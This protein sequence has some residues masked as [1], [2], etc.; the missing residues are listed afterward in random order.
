[1]SNKHLNQYHLNREFLSNIIQSFKEHYFD[2]KITVIF[3]CATHLI[4]AYAHDEKG[5]ALG[6]RHTDVFNFLKN[7][8]G[9]NSKPFKSFGNLYRNSRDSRYNGFTTRSN[10]ERICQYKFN[11][12]ISHLTHIKQYLEAKGFNCDIPGEQSEGKAN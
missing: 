3:Y 12:S 7:E 5:M 11:E 9:E 4:R 1:M 2:W 10:F 6:N 8:C